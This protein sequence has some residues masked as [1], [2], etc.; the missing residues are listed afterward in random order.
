M[1][2]VSIT[3]DCTAL[4]SYIQLLFEISTWMFPWHLKLNVAPVNSVPS[5]TWAPIPGLIISINQTTRLL[6]SK[7]LATPSTPLSLTPNIESIC[8]F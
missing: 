5:Q 4:D 8:K 6:M 2:P 1:W 3:L 7:T